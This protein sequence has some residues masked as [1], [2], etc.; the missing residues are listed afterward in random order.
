MSAARPDLLP[1]GVTGTGAVVDQKL[2]WFGT[3][4]GRG[5]FLFSP[6]MLLYATGGLAY[7]SLK[8]DITLGG[9]TPA[10]VPVF[11]AV[12]GSNTRVG[13]TIGG[14]G[15]WKFSPNWSAKLEY[16]Y[17]D[18]GRTSNTAFLTTGPGTGVGVNLTSRVTDNIF[19]GGINYQFSAY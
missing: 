18:I 19:R 14:G 7:G 9:F 1:P 10:G 17:M 8:T 16:L 15:E 13:W 6:T 11:A 2:E 12:S 3:F 4:R 5:G